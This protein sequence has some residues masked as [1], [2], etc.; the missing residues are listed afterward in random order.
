MDTEY[1]AKAAEHYEGEGRIL[2]RRME[3]IDDRTPLEAGIVRLDE[4]LTRL[5]HSIKEQEERLAPVLR[6]VGA[7]EGASLA[8]PSEDH[9]ERVQQLAHLADRL[10]AMT[11]S[12]QHITARVEA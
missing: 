9:S 2:S 12:L 4:L 7:D 8:R 1:E 5:A 11:D 3:S 10:E 6:A